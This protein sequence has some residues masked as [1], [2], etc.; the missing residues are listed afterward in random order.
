M[1]GACHRDFSQTFYTEYYS[2][3]IYIREPLRLRQFPVV[4]I[5]RIATDPRP[6]L[7]VQ[8]VDAGTNQRATAETT[9]TSV[10]LFRIASAT[11]VTSDL[12]F[13]AYPTLADM[14]MAINALRRGLG[15]AGD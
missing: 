5:T 3:G 13:A 2:G 6:A 9:P 4:E 1:R 11:P 8:N 15:L 14:A 12:S 7:L 10:R